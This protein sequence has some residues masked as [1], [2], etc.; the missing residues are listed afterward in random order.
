MRCG[1]YTDAKAVLREELKAAGCI[2]YDSDA[3]YLLFYS[4]KKLYE[5]FYSVVF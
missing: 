4:E 3:D 5:L 2:V 1:L